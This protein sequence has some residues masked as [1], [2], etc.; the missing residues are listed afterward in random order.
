MVNKHNWLEDPIKGIYVKHERLS[1]C[2]SAPVKQRASLS[3]KSP[4]PE[5]IVKVTFYIKSSQGL[6]NIHQYV[7]HG[8]EQMERTLLFLMKNG[9]SFRLI[10]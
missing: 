6:K 7:E 9:V 4:V 5:A 8:S 2:C 3:F 10:N 1:F